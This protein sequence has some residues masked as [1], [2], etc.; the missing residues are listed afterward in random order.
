MLSVLYK[1]QENSFG[2][3]GNELNHYYTDPENR[4]KAV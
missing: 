3:D 4:F 2:K 1:I